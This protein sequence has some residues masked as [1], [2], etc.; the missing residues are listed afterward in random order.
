MTF[1]VAAVALAIERLQA[2]LRDDICSQHMNKSNVTGFLGELLVLK[3]LR[4]AGEDVEPRGNQAGDDLVVSALNAKLDVK[5]STV[6]QELGDGFR[7]WGWALTSTAKKRQ[8][9]ATH[10]VC[11]A[12]DNDYA[13]ARLFVV[14]ASEM[15]RFPPGE[16]RFKSVTHCLI[17]PVDQGQERSAVQG[18]NASRLK[19]CEALLGDGTVQVALPTE[20][21]RLVAAIR[22]SAS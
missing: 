16:R 12:L 2:V 9:T 10:F 8:V 5:C 17:V 20:G 21:A 19:S 1:E 13:L 14:R 22:G 7:H 6:K 3:L 18:F 4:D 15:S 11:V